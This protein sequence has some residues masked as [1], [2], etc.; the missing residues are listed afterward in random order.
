MIRNNITIENADIWA[1]NF[2]GVAKRFN[3]E[4]MQNFCVFLDPE[5]AEVLKHDGWNVR[6]LKPRDEEEVEKPYL[7]VAVRFED[8]LSRQRFN[9]KL[10][11]ISSRGKSL[12]DKDS[13]KILDW[14]EIKKVDLTIRPY[15]WDVSGKSGVKA[16]L[17]SIFVTVV[18]DELDLKYYDVPDNA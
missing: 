11:L 6:W 18:E 14:A 10:V 17:K 7:Q 9:P 8:D 15:N 4:G 5:V 13:V 12:L 16:Y 1:R 2:T 3:A